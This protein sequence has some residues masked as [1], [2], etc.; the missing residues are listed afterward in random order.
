[1]YFFLFKI[2]VVLICVIGLCENIGNQRINIVVILNIGND[3]GRN[4][5][6]EKKFKN[7]VDFE[8]KNL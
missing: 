5:G 8:F 1:M 7:L 3:Q 6:K 4:C 2:I